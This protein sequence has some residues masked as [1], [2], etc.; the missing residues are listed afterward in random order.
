VQSRAPIYTVSETA[1]GEGR[2]V[3]YERL[4]LPLGDDEGRVVRILALLETISSEGKIERWQL[5][6]GG[7]AA[8][9]VT[10]RAELR[11]P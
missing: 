5:M 2:P 1:D 11:I 7:R 10:V 8:P 9:T 3:L 4:L 6:T